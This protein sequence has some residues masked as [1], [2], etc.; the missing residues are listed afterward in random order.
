MIS[1]EVQRTLVKSPPE[2]WSE[3]SDEA[4]LARHLSGFRRVRITHLS[5][6]E[7]IDW[8]ADGASGSILIS[9]SGWGTRVTLT[10]ERESARPAATAAQPPTATPDAAPPSVAPEAV[11]P[12][13]TPAAPPAAPAGASAAPAPAA[14][15]PASSASQPAAAPAA[16]L[17]RDS[18]REHLASSEAA[19]T[20]G[21][22]IE[23]AGEPVAQAAA[24]D[25]AAIEPVGEP[26]TQ[27]APER[28][29]SPNEHAA[30][31]EPADAT[32]RRG[33]FAR[34]LRGWHS[35]LEWAER[36]SAEAKPTPDPPAA[37][38][39][40]A[41]AGE[42]SPEVADGTAGEA[43]PPE[44]ENG[45]AGAAPD[46]PSRARAADG[47]DAIE[48]PP[49]APTGSPAAADRDHRDL[50]A[51]LRAAEESASEGEGD[52]AVLR[53]VL[54]SLGSAHHRPFSRS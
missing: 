43:S 34:L 13:D 38:A 28:P 35:A 17:A 37:E 4:A 1:S 31:P 21:G 32:P 2:L 5:A 9:P 8:A 49:A 48:G 44:V 30:G 26:V 10:L 46:T 12:P 29:E 7:R 36:P 22:G 53:S 24:T 50:S 3:L 20:A 42:A 18:T 6:E 19:A 25:G 51:E 16:Q 33:F 40:S 41:A 11:S 23:S 47:G 15:A 39:D 14:A 54:D 45:T 27:A 52:A